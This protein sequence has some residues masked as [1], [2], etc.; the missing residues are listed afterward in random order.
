[1]ETFK[2][3]FNDLGENIGGMLNSSQQEIDKIKYEYEQGE[4]VT[5]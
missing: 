3:L 2:V 4:I 5:C 1:M